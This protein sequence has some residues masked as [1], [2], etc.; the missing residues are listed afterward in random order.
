MKVQNN[1]YLSALQIQDQFLSQK[2]STH[3]VPLPKGSAS[4]QDIL[5]EKTGRSDGGLKFSKHAAG[6]LADR[7]I[8]LTDEQME[9]LSDEI[10]RAHV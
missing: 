4:F 10:G 2:S 8:R 9:R 3:K 6:R 7:N 5:A 1:P